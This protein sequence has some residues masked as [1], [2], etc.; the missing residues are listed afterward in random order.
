MCVPVELLQGCSSLHYIPVPIYQG[1]VYE[2]QVVY[3]EYDKDMSVHHWK[4][5]LKKK[6]HRANVPIDYLPIA[7]V[8]GH[9]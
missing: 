2:G 9:S 6:L 4:T 1:V 5:E 7:H 3:F 8:Y